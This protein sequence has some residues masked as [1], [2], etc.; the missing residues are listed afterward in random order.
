MIINQGDNDIIYQVDAYNVLT[1]LANYTTSRLVDTGELRNLIVKARRKL[2]ELE[3]V[4][5]GVMYGRS[6]RR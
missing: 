3:N 5:M 6:E 1:E 4:A 2:D